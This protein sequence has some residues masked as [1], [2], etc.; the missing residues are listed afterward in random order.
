M[1]I[2]CCGYVLALSSFWL[3]YRL[4]AALNILSP[5]SRLP[6]AHWSAHNS[7]RWLRQACTDVG[8][9]KTLYNAHHTHGSIV[10]I[11]PNEVSVI[12]EEGLRKIYVGGL[13]KSDW[14]EQ[15]FR[16]YGKPNLV[17]TLDHKTHAAV[18]RMIAGSYAKSYLQHAGGLRA[19]STRIIRDRLFPELGQLAN[20]GTGTNVMELFECM[21]MD[22]VTGHLFGNSISTDLLGDKNNRERYFEEWQRASGSAAVAR[23]PL[24]EALILERSRAA[25]DEYEGDTDGQQD[26]QPVVVKLYRGMHEHAK[27]TGLDASE[28]ITQCASEMVD[29]VIATQE[30]V[31]IT[32][33]YIF[34][35]LSQRPALQESLRAQLQR[36][37]ATGTGDG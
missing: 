37:Y 6:A 10:R 25:I 36:L 3:A 5:L 18:R 2:H 1:F 32:W 20:S 15:V 26:R 35:R 28:V 33:T 34:Y 23:R 30:T 21:A 22:F 4:L 7:S 24:T 9:L 12:S 19:L 29:H 14:Y 27:R 31:S 8:E 13:D 17:C 16:V 11:A